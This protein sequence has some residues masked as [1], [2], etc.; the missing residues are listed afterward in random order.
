M[1]CH[2]KRWIDMSL[3]RKMIKIEGIVQGVGFRPTVFRYAQELNLTGSILNDAQGVF[4]E[5]QGNFDQTDRFIKKFLDSPPPMARIDKVTQYS[6]PILKG[7]KEFIIKMSQSKGVKEV[8]ISPDIKVCPDCL[9]ELFDDKNRRYK[10]PFINCTNCGPR[11][12]II[13]DRPYDRP[14]TSMSDFPFCGDC[15]DEYENPLDKRFH[16]QPNACP[17]CGPSL[18]ILGGHLPD[19][20]DPLDYTIQKLKEGFVAGIKGIGGF[21]LAA[22]PFNSHKKGILH[23]RQAKRRP[24]KSFALMAK[25]IEVVK[26][27]AEVNE[28]E[29]KALEG[30]RAP[31][32]LLK[33]KSGVFTL[34]HVSVDNN[35]LGFILPYTPLHY[36][37]MKHFDCLI[38][39]SANLIDEPIAVNDDEMSFLINNNVAHFALTNNR[40]ILHRA[41]DSILQFINNQLQIIRYSRGYTPQHFN[42]EEGIKTET[43]ILALGSN[44]KNTFAFHHQNKVFL[45][46]HIGELID[47]ESHIF[48]RNEI[49][50]LAKL[51]S[52]PAEREDYKIVTDLHPSYENFGDGDY[53]CQ[54]H[55]AHLLSV[56]GEHK[57]L[58][59]KNKIIGIMADGTGHGT[60]GKIWGFELL[61]P[62]KGLTD[63]DRIGSLASFPLIGAEKAIKDIVKIKY[64]LYSEAGLHH[65]I[66]HAYQKI[67]ELKLNSP[68]TSS[69]GRLFDGVACIIGLL[70]HVDYEAR[71][72]ILL[73]KYAEDYVKPIGKK[74]DKLPVQIDENNQIQFVPLIQEIVT[75]I[76]QN[77]KQQH[78]IAYLFHLWVIDSFIAL[79][80]NSDPKREATILLSGGVFQNQLLMT[81]TLERL[82]KHAYTFYSNNQI[83]VNDAGLSF[84]QI[85][86][87]MMM[88]KKGK[89]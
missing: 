77:A 1:Y 41:D 13:R 30:P 28:E 6:L 20:Q 42:L 9:R 73:Q 71:A 57:L 54:H 21:N 82:K 68:M 38:M 12:T 64:G 15:L 70:D 27:Y 24:T 78:E 80:E 11:F 53:Q 10:Y 58:K 36:L 65:L 75:R 35:Y 16:A 62:K 18:S 89:E 61:T 55:F 25:S 29:R 23:L 43:P 44:M 22:N 72:A 49:K 32:V 79:L 33:K 56:M 8:A 63:F 5:I 60:D 67:I 19:N 39:T 46:Q 7:E 31:I 45:S 2:A 83:P 4:L 47:P 50:D 51:L 66:P 69:L 14:K 74:I 34:D 48:Q 17:T 59:T 87:G 26:R 84:G 81:L 76:N 40:P 52:F 86:Y 3:I 37:L 88:E 85:I